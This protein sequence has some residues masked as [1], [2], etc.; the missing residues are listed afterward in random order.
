MTIKIQ[1]FPVGVNQVFLKELGLT[2]RHF[3]RILHLRTELLKTEEVRVFLRQSWVHITS[4]IENY[5]R[6][7]LKN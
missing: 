2:I 4:I 1:N 3:Q 6:I 5:F 7:Y